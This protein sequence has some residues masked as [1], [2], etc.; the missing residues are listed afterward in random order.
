MSILPVN[1]IGTGEFTSGEIINPS[2][3]GDVSGYF[4]TNDSNWCGT[5]AFNVTVCSPP[6]ETLVSEIVANSPSYTPVPT[7]VST[8]EP[9]STIM[10]V[11][12]SF[13]MLRYFSFR[14]SRVR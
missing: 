12:I 5:S 6:A 14:K 1:P 10:I 4:S 11:L 8:P 9:H 7:V 2:D 13:L 3:Y